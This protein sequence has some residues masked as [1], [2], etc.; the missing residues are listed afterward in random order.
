MKL[1][2]FFAA[3]ALAVS[4]L[5]DLGYSKYQGVDYGNGISSW[6]GMRYAA[7]PVGDMRFRAPADPVRTRGVQ[8]ADKVRMTDWRKE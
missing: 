7:P 3:G 4:P 2:T 8:A 6:L 5:V 1:L